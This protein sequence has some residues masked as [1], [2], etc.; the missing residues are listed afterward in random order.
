VPNL[1]ALQTESFDWLVGNDAWKVRVDGDATALPR[2][3]ELV[4]FPPSG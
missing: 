4:V 2:L 1:L 3:L